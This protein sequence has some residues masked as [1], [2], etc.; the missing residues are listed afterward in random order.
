MTNSQPPKKDDRPTYGS[1]T[2]NNNRRTHDVYRPAEQ[3]SAMDISQSF[4]NHRS[5]DTRDQAHGIPAGTQRDRS[6]FSPPRGPRSFMERGLDSRSRRRS[7][8]PSQQRASK[9]R[10]DTGRS[11]EDSL[12]ARPSVQRNDLMSITNQPTVQ[13]QQLANVQHTIVHQQTTPNQQIASSNNVVGKQA[14]SF[15]SPVQF[16][17]PYLESQIAH[18]RRKFP[19]HSQAYDGYEYT[20]KGDGQPPTKAARAIAEFIMKIKDIR[21]KPGDIDGHWLRT[22]PPAVLE[23]C[24]RLFNAVGSH[25]NA[26]LVSERYSAD[27]FNHDLETELQKI[28]RGTVIATPVIQSLSDDNVSVD[29]PNRMNSTYGPALVKERLCVVTAVRGYDLKIVSSTGFGNK[30]KPPNSNRRNEYAEFAHKD[31]PSELFTELV[32]RFDGPWNPLFK[33]TFLHHGQAQWINVKNSLFAI[34]G[35]VVPEDF[36]RLINLIQLAEEPFPGKGGK[37]VGR[38]DYAYGA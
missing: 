28:T 17:D 38:T 10:R 27:E 34:R 1:H 21:I 7:R 22:L 9:R 2:D 33:R 3:Q 30:G 29:S 20:W 13:N 8:S 15:Q 35:R 25:V 19:G 24:A 14:V 11:Q 32:I 31:D 26:A 6:N 23:N 18:G 16:A 5:S 37:K 12:P 4:G 36:E